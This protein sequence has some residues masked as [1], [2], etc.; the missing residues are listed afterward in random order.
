[1]I[2]GG[3]VIAQN[4]VSTGQLGAASGT[5][6]EVKCGIDYTVSQRLK[7]IRDR[8]VAL[9]LKLKEVE[10]L[11]QGGREGEA[12]LTD[13]RE[14]LKAAILKLTE[15]AR[16]L[17]MGLDKNEAAEIVVFGTVHPGTV[18][19]I[20]NIPYAVERPLDHVVFSLD[21]KTGKVTCRRLAATR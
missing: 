16:A 8:N 12:K 1:M 18:I 10:Q 21:K 2:V 3:I 9:A 14:K 11:I 7:W 4:G 6:T 15:A 20:C 19:E 13:L 5:R 17:V